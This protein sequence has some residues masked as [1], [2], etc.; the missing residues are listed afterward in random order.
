MRLESSEV[1][2]CIAYVIQDVFIQTFEL[3]VAGRQEDFLKATV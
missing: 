2:H 3:I 1:R